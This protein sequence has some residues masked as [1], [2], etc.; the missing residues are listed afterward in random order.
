MFLIAL[1]GPKPD[2]LNER[3]AESPDIADIWKDAPI[4][5]G[6]TK[7]DPLPDVGTIM[8]TGGAGFM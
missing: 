7:F 5:K 6:T 1:V 2:R 3:K 4:L 8:I